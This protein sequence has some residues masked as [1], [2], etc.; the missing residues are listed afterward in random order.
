MGSIDPTF[1]LHKK[2]YATVAGGFWPR[3]GIS[4]PGYNEAANQ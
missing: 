1:R 4:D 2:S 3:T